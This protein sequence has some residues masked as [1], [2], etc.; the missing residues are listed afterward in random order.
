[1]PR[2]VG[3]RRLTVAMCALLRATEVAVKDGL[4]PCVR[5]LF[6]SGRQLVGRR[7]VPSALFVDRVFDGYQVLVVVSWGGTNFQ[8]VISSGVCAMS[9]GLVTRYLSFVHVGGYNHAGVGGLVFHAGRMAVTATCLAVAMV[10]CVVF[11]LCGLGPLIGFGAIGSVRIGNG[12]YVAVL[13]C[14]GLV[15]RLLVYVGYNTISLVRVREVGRLSVFVGGGL[16]GRLLVN[17]S[18][19]GGWDC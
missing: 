16:A 13:M 18:N 17:A 10:V 4:V 15:C 14:T 3:G 1:M 12:C 7:R 2:S 11:V 6:Q 8:R 9:G 19:G 5:V